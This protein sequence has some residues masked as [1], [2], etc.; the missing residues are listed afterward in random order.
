MNQCDRFAR[1]SIAAFCAVVGLTLGAATAA[2]AS[3]ETDFR[4]ICLA[5]L[6]KIDAQVSA[7][8]GAGYQEDVSKRSE[9][10]FTLIKNDGG[11]ELSINFST[12]PVKATRVAPAE[13]VYQ[14]N[15]GGPDDGHR[16]RDIQNWVGFEGSQMGDGLVG[17][18]FTSKAGKQSYLDPKDQ[19]G[20]LSAL[21]GQGYYLML[22]YTKPRKISYILVHFEAA[23]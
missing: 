6:G 19:A 23:K 11:D 4:A 2:E 3:P 17:Y 5:N 12:T 18:S 8:R 10:G 9:R 14:C 7:A 21:A 1:T 20:T 22:V 16:T 15:A 13:T